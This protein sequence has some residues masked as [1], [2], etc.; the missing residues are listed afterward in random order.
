MVMFEAEVPEETI[1]QIPKIGIIGPV[2]ILHLTEV[3]YVGGKLR[4]Q[5][6]TELIHTSLLL[7]LQNTLVLRLPVWSLQALPGKGPTQEVQSHVAQRFEIVAARRD[8]RLRYQRM[9]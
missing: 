2:G 1:K 6:S 4:W 8:W 5:V 3:V 9:V 7:L